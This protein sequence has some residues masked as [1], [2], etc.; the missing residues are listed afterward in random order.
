MLTTETNLHVYNAPEVASHYARLDYLTPCEQFLFETYI[1]PGASILDL[2]VGGGRI[3][4]YLSRRAGRY[5]GVDYASE[6]VH[7][8]RSRFPDT[9]FLVADAASL[10]VFPDASFDVIVMAF[11]A[12]DYVIPDSHRARCLREIHRVLRPDGIFIFSSHNPRSI[13]VRP[14]WNRDSLRR[15]AAQLAGEARPMFILILALLTCFKA[16]LAGINSTASSCARIMRRIATS[17]FWNGD[18]YL[19]DPAH[20]GL[21]THY[22]TPKRAVSVLESFHFSWQ[23]KLGDDYPRSSN[24]YI[25]DWYY[26]VFGKSRN[27]KDQQACA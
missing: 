8:C 6:M 27:P 16:F 13:L 19:L 18:G 25:T 20:G 10:D 23:R 12:I 7:V 5:V 1:K 24:R 9:E 11:N 14:D 2:G 3:T 4:P 21:V 26:Y 17:A 15:C 22:W